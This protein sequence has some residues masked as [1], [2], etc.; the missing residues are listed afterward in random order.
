[1]KVYYI[2]KLKKEFVNLYRD[3]P[4]VLYNILKSIYYLDTEEVT[5]GYNLFKQLI[6]PLNK[7]KLDKDLFIKFHS[8]IPYSKRKNTHYINNLY[9]N[10]VSR[11][12][13]NN[14]YIRLEVEQNFSTFFEILKKEN[15]NLFVCSFKTCDFFF[16]DEYP[17]KLLV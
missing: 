16:L 7:N 15:N 1:M 11:M 2:F 3:T 13:I 4:S 14:F 6:I 9:R 17:S 12:S 10:E 5:Y 8:D